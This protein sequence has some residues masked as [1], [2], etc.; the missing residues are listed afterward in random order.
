MAS[1]ESIDLLA[2]R[3]PHI[4]EEAGHSQL[5]SVDFS[6]DQT[7][8]PT[9]LV[10]AKYL[11]ARNGNVEQAAE[12]LTKTLKWNKD[13]NPRAAAFEERFGEDY[14]DLA[15]VTRIGEQVVVWNLYGAFSYPE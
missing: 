3:L 6:H 10:L 4:I 12:A 2:A 11:K 14:E 1:S 5:F 9:K 7:S 15:F 8:P 13:F